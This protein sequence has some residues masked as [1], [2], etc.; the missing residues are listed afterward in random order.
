MKLLY[1]NDFRLGVLKGD[2]VVD[3]TSVVQN[4]P[5]T[6]PGDLMNGLIAR[7]SD[8]RAP[9]ERAAST[10]AG[11]PVA[12]VKIRPPLPKPVNIDCMAVN[13]MEDGTRKAPAPRLHG[14][15]PS[16]HCRDSAG[17]APASLALSVIW[18]SFARRLTF[19]A[20]AAEPP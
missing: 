11:V 13:Y 18:K 10:G 4:I 15:H 16:D 2:N 3:V 17:V 20:Y 14:R 5:H 8:F 19:C 6:G 7:F 9:L 1:F 12:Q